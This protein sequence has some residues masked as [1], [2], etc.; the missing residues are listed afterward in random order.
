M[1]RV[2]RVILLA[3]GMSLAT[4]GVFA[5]RDVKEARLALTQDSKPSASILILGQVREPLLSRAA[6]LLN[7]TVEQW[8]GVSL[9]VKQVAEQGSLPGRSIVLTTLANLQRYCPALNTPEYPDI[10]RV[11][12]LDEQGYACVPIAGG[13]GGTM[14]VVAKTPRGVYNG[15]IY[16]RDFGIDGTKSHLFVRSVTTV[17]T[18]QMQARGTYCLSIYGVAPQYT[19]ADWHKIFD[20][21][22]R[23]GM[24]RVYFW[25]SGHFPSKQFPQTYNRDVASGTRIGSVAALEDLIR[26]AHSL[27]IKFYLGSGAFAWGDAAYVAEGVPGAQAVKAGGLCPSNAIA[28]QRTHDYFL[29]MID[30]LPDSDGFFLEM[31]DEQGECQ[32][33]ICQQPIDSYGSKQYG[34]SEITFVQQLAADIW[35]KHP[36]VHFCNNIGYAEHKNDVAFYHQVRQMTDPRFEWLDCRWAWALPVAGGQRLPLSYFSPKAI[37]WG[38]F[39][40]RSLD[41]MDTMAHKVGTD[42]LYGYVPAFEPGF[43]TASYYANSVPFPTDILPYNVTGFIY[44][45]LS[46]SPRLTDEELKQRLEAGFFGEEAPKNVGSDLWDLREWVVKNAQIMVTY[47]Q[48]WISYDTKRIPHPTLADQVRKAESQSAGDARKTE[49]TRLLKVVTDLKTIRDSSLASLDQIERDMQQARVHAGPKTLETLTGMQVA[50]DDSRK[51]F[52]AAVPDPAALD[53]Y[54]RRLTALAQ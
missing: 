46:W 37:H 16:L 13:D 33:P 7:R 5:S 18:P 41:E 6:A 52:H 31:R 21:F 30:A 25:V 44:R 54:S 48:D 36:N 19:T 14:L 23:D 8:G 12:F 35:K 20:S 28:R 17:R 39:Y 24:E 49:A 50:I 43:A 42:G 47:S 45:E 53:D 9:P 29:E 1:N 15:A 22:A 3:A 51:A 38:P 4:S 40:S 27:G 34:R 32:C 2:L 26:Y 10:L 11:A